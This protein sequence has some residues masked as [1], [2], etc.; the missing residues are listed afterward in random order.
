MTHHNLA[1]IQHVEPVSPCVCF[2]LRVEVPVVHLAY[3]YSAI[4]LYC[5]YPPT[6]GYNVVL[7]IEWRG[8][9]TIPRLILCL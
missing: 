8:Y 7:R 9:L 5:V 3:G 2:L 4:I 1:V 6:R